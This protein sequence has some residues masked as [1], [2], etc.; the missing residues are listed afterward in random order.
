VPVVVRTLN[1]RLLW[2]RSAPSVSPW[3]QTTELAA[4]ALHDL[5]TR[6]NRLSI[7]L[8]NTLDSPDLNR[9]LAAVGA[10][11]TNLDKIDYAAFDV[12]VLDDLGVT[13]E[14]T[15]GATP[16]E[17]VNQ[18]HHDLIHL[19]ATKVA[20]LGVAIRRQAT[21]SR[22]SPGEVRALI[23]DAVAKD[24]IDRTKLKPEIAAKIL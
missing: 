15:P 5:R 16:D 17:L 1:Y 3:L 8:V 9:V 18:W 4:D 24:Q 2:D 20:E 23:R 21:V 19:T 11:R 6:D 13:I 14:P 12:R 7:F 22:K 10:N